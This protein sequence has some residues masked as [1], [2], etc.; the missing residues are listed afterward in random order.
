M[1]EPDGELPES[2]LREFHPMAFEFPRRDPDTLFF[3]TVHVHDGRVHAE[4]RFDHSLFWQSDPP[5]EPPGGESFA[6]S[7]EPTASFMDMARTAG[8]VEARLPCRAVYLR[9]PRHNQDMV[10]RRLPH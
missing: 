2:T 7:R 9:G 10:F 4:A 5:C 1:G 3:P 6:L 8:T